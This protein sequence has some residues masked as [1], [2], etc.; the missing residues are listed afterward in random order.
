MAMI[1]PGRSRVGSWALLVRAPRA[2][3]VVVLCG[4]DVVRELTHLCCRPHGCAGPC[5][6][7]PV[8]GL[9]LHRFGRRIIGCRH[10]W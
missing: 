3:S 7:S 10:V 5:L 6:L 4:C 9:L 8:R 1:P 2:P